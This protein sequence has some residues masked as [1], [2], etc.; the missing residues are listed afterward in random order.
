MLISTAWTWVVAA[1]AFHLGAADVSP[2]LL[3]ER[4][5]QKI[6]L[7]RSVCVAP[8]ALRSEANIDSIVDAF[9]THTHGLRL[10]RLTIK[11]CDLAT[12]D[13]VQAVAIDGNVVQITERPGGVPL[14]SQK[15][16][17]GDIRQFTIHGVRFELYSFQLG[18][19]EALCEIRTGA[20]PSARMAEKVSALMTDRFPEL[21]ISI[22]LTWGYAAPSGLDPAPGWLPP[23][24]HY[25]CF[26]AR[27]RLSE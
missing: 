18:R 17:A 1:M 16:G 4:R 10:L 5:I 12:G 11:A 14:I 26:R 19:R 21:R 23:G 3:N 6:A 24:D 25:F 8:D 22:V 7:D 2:K 9:L 15:R 27:C 20:K 13:V